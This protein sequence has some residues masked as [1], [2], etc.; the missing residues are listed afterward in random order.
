MVV[1]NK[2]EEIEKKPEE[3][4]EEEPKVAPAKTK[5][6]KQKACPKDRVVNQV[7]SLLFITTEYEDPIGFTKVKGVM[8]EAKAAEDYAKQMGQD[9]RVYHNLSAS[10]VEEKIAMV[11]QETEDPPP[12]GCR[13]IITISIGPGLNPE[14]LSDD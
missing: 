2:V 1:E 9:V 7:I 8:E 6:R 14:K 11:Q 3:Q 5:L 13:L 4:I 12:S 10:G